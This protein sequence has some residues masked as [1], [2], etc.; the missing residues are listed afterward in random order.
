MLIC[1][2]LI[3]LGVWCLEITRKSSEGLTLRVE[4]TL[5]PFQNLE[6]EYIHI[7]I[8]A[9]FENVLYWHSLKGC[10]QTIL[11]WGCVGCWE[12]PSVTWFN[13]RQMRP[14]TGQ[15]SPLLQV[16]WQCK[17]FGY[18]F[19]TCTRSGTCM[20]IW[21]FYGSLWYLNSTS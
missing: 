16:Y 1:G 19:L 18:N 17:V 5:T 7:Y 9:T 3:S 12:D 11:T 6:Y 21:I 10:L 2:C 8:Y 15:K 20:L 4:S 14:Q 13:C